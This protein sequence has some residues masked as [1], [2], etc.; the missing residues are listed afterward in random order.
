MPHCLSGIYDRRKGAKVFSPRAAEL[1]PGGDRVTDEIVGQNEVLF[2]TLSQMLVP[3]SVY[4]RGH[5]SP[6]PCHRSKARATLEPLKV[7]ARRTRLQAQDVDLVRRAYLVVVL[8]VRERERKHALLL[9]VR[10][11][12]A[13]ERAHDDR[14]A[15]EEARLERRVLTRRTL[16]VVMV[17]DHDPLDAVVAVVGR[18][19]R[20]GAILAGDLV[21]DLVR[22][23]VLSVDRA[24]QTVLRDVLEEY[25]HRCGQSLKM[26]C[27]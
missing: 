26:P 27:E 21:L 12:D 18:V 9:R 19:L 1:T 24:N 23:V 8:R 14:Q 15:A 7:L 5:D 22:L 11:V 10:L 4:A 6:S 17:A 20:D 13:R 25:Q 3:E 2:D 16:A